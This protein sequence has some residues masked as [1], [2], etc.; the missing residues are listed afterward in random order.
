MKQISIRASLPRLFASGDFFL[1]Q[2]WTSNRFASSNQQGRPARWSSRGLW[3]K[4]LLPAVSFTR[5]LGN[6]RLGSPK[7]NKQMSLVNTC[8]VTFIVTLEG[9]ECSLNVKSDIYGL[10]ILCHD[11]A[12][13]RLKRK[14][15]SRG[16]KY[17][18]TP[19]TRSL[20][21]NE[22]QFELQLGLAR[23]RVIRVDCEIQFAN[24]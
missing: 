11:H 3:R 17:S 19:V 10:W 1:T 7:W 20:K 2:I 6:G 15:F 14:D 24:L 22:K 16:F 13:H 4:L 18:K 9:K 21:G 8:R 12:T 5:L 23:V